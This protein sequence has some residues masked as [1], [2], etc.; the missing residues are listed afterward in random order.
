MPPSDPASKRAWCPTRRR[1][2]PPKPAA[3]PKPVAVAP[4]APRRRHAGRAA[5]NAVALAPHPA[6]RPQARGFQQGL[7][8]RAPAA[9]SLRS[10]AQRA[11]STRSL[12]AR[13]GVPAKRW[14]WPSAPG[15]ARR[16]DEHHPR[17]R[18]ARRAGSRRLAVDR[19]HAGAHRYLRQGD[20]RLPV[21]PRRSASARS[22][23]PSAAPSRMASSRCRS[24]RTFPSRRSPSP[25]GAW[26]STTA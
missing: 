26:A 23:R 9:A 6:R 21:D 20:R 12:P 13:R 7:G 3:V 8:R 17:A 10:G 22:S 15:K 4:A 18:V 5:R 19:D 25:T 11:R 16:R 1:R 14:R 24:S 2:L